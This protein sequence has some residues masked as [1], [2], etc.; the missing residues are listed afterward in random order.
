MAASVPWVCSPSSHFHCYRAA[1]FT[2]F[3]KMVPF[4]MTRTRSFAFLKWPFSSLSS[5]KFS[6]VYAWHPVGLTLMMGAWS[7]L[8]AGNW[9]TEHSNGRWGTGWID[10]RPPADEILASLSKSA[11]REI[12]RAERVGV[13]TRT[14]TNI[15]EAREFL[16]SLNG[17]R[18][19]S[20]VESDF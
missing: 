10:I 12:R 7:A 4:V 8:A 5:P 20:R 17:L 13:S 3:A 6:G 1:D 18:V 15:D 2:P 16:R 14:L 11:R 9:I 19:V